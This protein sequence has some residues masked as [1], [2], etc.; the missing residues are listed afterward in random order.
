MILGSKHLKGFDYAR[1]GALRSDFPKK[2]AVGAAYIEG[3]KII[4]AG[5][6]TKTSPVAKRYGSR[7]ERLHAEMNCLQGI[8]ASGGELYVY[9]E[10]RN[11]KI[12]LARPCTVC[13]PLLLEHG[14]RH[15]FYTTED[16]YS[17][18]DLRSL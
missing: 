7:Y 4:I 17:Y 11:G 9:R 6:S 5:N 3:S 2:K 16:G 12:A 8:D 15:V 13:I 14:C 18:L 10:H 1:V